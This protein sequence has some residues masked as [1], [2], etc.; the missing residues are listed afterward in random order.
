MVLPSPDTAL[1]TS[2]VLAPSE[3][4][5]ERLLYK[6]RKGSSSIS[7]S[8]AVRARP[9]AGMP[10]SARMPYSFS[11][12]SHDLT[13]VLTRLSRNASPTPSRSPKTSATSAVALR[14]GELGDSGTAAV[15][16]TLAF[17]VATACASSS[18]CDRASRLA[19]SV[20]AAAGSEAM[21]WAIS[22]WPLISCSSLC[23]WLYATNCCANAL[24]MLAASCALPSVTETSM[25]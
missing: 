15:L 18:F 17:A 12:S 21:R 10:A 19:R 3:A 22:F 25:T 8:T 11:N 13:R 24:A 14:F 20:V 5:S 16:A 6:M 9:P 1:V 2:T 7:R 23:F 4:S